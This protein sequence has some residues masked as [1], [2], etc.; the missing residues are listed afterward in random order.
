[1][2]E[3]DWEDV[4]YDADFFSPDK[5]EQD[6]HDL[7]VKVAWMIDSRQYTGVSNDISSG[8]LFVASEQIPMHGVECK[9]AFKLP[10]CEEPIRAIARVAWS[11]FEAGE[12]P[13]EPCGFGVEF[14]QLSPR[15]KESLHEYIELSD[16]LL[17][18]GSDF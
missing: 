12:T 3:I 16:A 14:L 9:M 4:F 6:R 8:G 7:R 1:M 11:R 5:R 18:S 10:N 13:E 15:G 2:N 17:F